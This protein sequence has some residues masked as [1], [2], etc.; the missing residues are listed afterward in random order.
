MCLSEPH[1][2]PSLGGAPSSFL[3]FELGGAPALGRGASPDELRCFSF[4]PLELAEREPL[5]GGEP[6]G[7][8]LLGT[9]LSTR[10]SGEVSLARFFQSRLARLPAQELLFGATGQ[11]LLPPERRGTLDVGDASRFDGVGA[12]RSIVP[13][14]ER[15]TV[16][17]LW[18]ITHGAIDAHVEVVVVTLATAHLRCHQRHAPELVFAHADRARV[19][20][21][22]LAQMR[23]EDNV[24]R[25]RHRIV[26]EGFEERPIARIIEAIAPVA[27]ARVAVR[28]DADEESLRDRLPALVEHVITDVG[29]ATALVGLVRG[30]RAAALGRQVAHREP[31]TRD[32]SCHGAGGA[33]EEPDE[34]ARAIAV[35][36]N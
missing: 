19:G 21:D 30:E 33:I 27:S 35:R 1:R 24:L 7:A 11:L 32:A 28:V 14:M 4:E 6:R 13:G 18:P 3:G 8:A 9:L 36:A 23:G 15:G 25:L 2:T 34:L 20:D 12:R 5:V 26:D 22:A 29:V 10:L 17:A 16:E 31:R